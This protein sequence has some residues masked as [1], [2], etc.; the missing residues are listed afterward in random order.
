MRKLASAVHF[1]AGTVVSS[2]VEAL[3]DVL[4]C[5]VS[6]GLEPGSSLGKQ[7]NMGSNPT[8][9]ANGLITELIKSVCVTSL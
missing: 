1:G 2:R 8:G 5:P 7:A 6:R 4:T 3:L 9:T